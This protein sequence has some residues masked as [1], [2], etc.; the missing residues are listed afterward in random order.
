[1]PSRR[2]VPVRVE[3]EEALQRGVRKIFARY[4]QAPGITASISPHTL[5]HFLRT[6]LKTQGIDDALIQSLAVTGSHLAARRAKEHCSCPC[7]HV[8][9]P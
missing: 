3:L 9:W 6:W 2:G 8:H 1:V 4:T 7:C 5:R